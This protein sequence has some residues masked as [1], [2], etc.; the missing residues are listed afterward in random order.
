MLGVG[1]IGT[2]LTGGAFICAGAGASSLGLSSCAHASKASLKRESKV[3]PG[4]LCRAT[5]RNV[6]GNDSLAAFQIAE[7]FRR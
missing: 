7:L 3:E 1:Q 5:S 6:R 4:S 2:I